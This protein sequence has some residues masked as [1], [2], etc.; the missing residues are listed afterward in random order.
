MDLLQHIQRGIAAA[1]VVH[2]H[3]EAQLAETFDLRLHKLKVFAD[4]AFRDLH[5][6]HGAVDARVVH[7]APYLLDHVAA[8]K[9]HA[10]KVDGL[11]NQIEPGVPLSLHLF[12]HLLQH[13]QVELVDQLGF[14]QGGYEFPRRQ[15]AENGIDP[16]GQRFL[17]AD[18]SIRGANDRLV[19]YPDPAF[20]QRAIQV[21]Y[22]VNVNLALFEH[23]LVKIRDGG[24]EF[25]PLLIPGKLGA[26]TGDVDVHPFQR[27]RI[28]ADTNGHALPAHGGLTLLYHLAKRFIHVVLVGHRREMV[29]VEAANPMVP[30]L[31]RQ[32]PGQVLDCLVAHFKAI[33]PV[34]VPQPDDIEIKHH[35]PQA[36]REHLVPRLLRK[37]EEMPH[38]GKIRQPVVI[39]LVIQV[40]NI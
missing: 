15:E 8:L 30:E 2:P 21:V 10:G 14:L 35:G 27:V 12:Q 28:N 4:H 9:I 38:V 7:P 34:V 16:S 11:G 24:T 31:P 33:L 18:L 6:Y 1:E 37:G 39:E 40:V 29:A 25:T 20:S 3:W 17:V 22:D 32:N 23:D 13:I 26:V 36:F 5:G 19:V